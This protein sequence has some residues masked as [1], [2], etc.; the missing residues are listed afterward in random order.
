MFLKVISIQNDANAFLE[1]LEGKSIKVKAQ[2]ISDAFWKSVKS[3][4]DRMKELVKKPYDLIVRSYDK[5]KKS[6]KAV[7]QNLKNLRKQTKNQPL[8]TKVKIYGKEAL[9]QVRSIR[10]KLSDKP[11][12]MVVE[13]KISDSFKKLKKMKEGFF[14][15]IPMGN[16]SALLT[17]GGEK[18]VTYLTDKLNKG[19]S[20]AWDSKESSKKNG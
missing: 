5:T 3:M 6:L 7:K 18:A 1:S 4:K 10:K 12:F 13:S 2:M 20:K 11:V 9:K 16:V 8:E 17:K 14:G 15:K 19:F